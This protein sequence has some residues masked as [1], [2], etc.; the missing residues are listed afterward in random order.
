MKNQRHP[1]IAYRI[2]MADLVNIA[3]AAAELDEAKRFYVDQPDEQKRLA[4]RVEQLHDM[5]ER[6]A[7]AGAEGIYSVADGSS[8][9]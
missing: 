9:A 8:D 5:V 7:G 4:Q 2:T 3:D 1:A 6:A